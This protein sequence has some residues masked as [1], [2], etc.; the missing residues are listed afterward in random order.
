[1]LR[2]R[3]WTGGVRRRVKALFLLRTA[4]AAATPLAVGCRD[5]VSP[6]R[7]VPGAPVFSNGSNGRAP[8]RIT[9]LGATGTGSATLF[10]D[11][12]EFDFDVAADLT[13][14]FSYKDWSVVRSDGSVGSITVGAN[15]ATAITTFRDRSAGCA[16]S[17]RGAEFGGVGRLD[18][19]T[20]V[21]FVAVACDLG[22]AG[23]GADFVELAVSSLG[24][25]KSG[26]VTSGD[27]VSKLALAFYVSPSGSPSSDGSASSPW[28][29]Q[30][31]L[32]HPAAVQPGD[33]IWLRGGV[34]SGLFA[35]YLTGTADRPIIVRQYPGER[36]TID[37][38]TAQHGLATLGAHTWFWGIEVMG[39]SGPAVVVYTSVGDRFINLVV[40]DAGQ[41]GV[42]SFT[43]S[44]S[45]QTEIHGSIVF[46][47]G[48][49]Y[50]QAHGIYAQND[51]ATGVFYLT[52]NIVFNNWARG[53]QVYGNN[54]TQ[55][56]PAISGFVIEGN[57]AFH[58]GAISIPV[59]HT[60][61]I[62]TGGTIPA[63]DIV[64]RRNYTYWNGPSPP[65]PD[66]LSLNVGYVMGPQNEDVVVEDNYVVGGLYLGKWTSAFV[67]RNV[68][69]DYA[70]PMVVTDSGVI[71]HTWDANQFHGD[72][73][74]PDW[75]HVPNAPAGFATWKAQTGFANPGGYAG[76]GEPPNLVVVR[77]NKYEAG[78]ANIVVYNWDQ[79][80]TVSVDVSGVLTPGDRYM[81]QNVQDFYGAPVASGT[82]DGSPLQLPMA[83]IT[84]P[85]PIG[86]SYTPAPVTGPVFN[87]FVLMR[88]P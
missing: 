27:V 38:T 47:N 11:L 39:G 32:N 59:N 51:V 74:L 43:R 21:N 24:Y 6:E 41:S 66:A 49:E 31:A 80:S 84:P 88:A 72:S 77:P 42:V 57:V 7:G 18:T 48:G 55:V 81:V 62:M 71:G 2:S 40:H 82:F 34:Y 19:G 78:R 1:M 25:S 76:T 30:T 29:L 69:Y 85:T 60:K 50:N 4:L 75:M 63:S 20:L 28:D 35:S 65:N 36:A 58:N 3:T 9:G 5:A 52:D 15:S 53:I 22:A 67:R 54:L 73:T 33:T 46:N 64:V 10:S 37:G 8:P 13:G 12:Q 68:V 87:V 86:R 56:N 45:R 16:D 23:S 14:R 79:R 70:G 61:Q 83:G 26:L 17:T 44:S